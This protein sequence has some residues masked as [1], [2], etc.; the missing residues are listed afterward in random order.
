MTSASQA[1]VERVSLQ[2]LVGPEIRNAT[3]TP[4]VHHGLVIWYFLHPSLPANFLSPALGLKKKKIR[5]VIAHLQ[6]DTIPTFPAPSSPQIPQ[7]P[8]VT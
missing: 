4:P 6:S 8:C 3:P 5:T 7:T 2:V 1:R